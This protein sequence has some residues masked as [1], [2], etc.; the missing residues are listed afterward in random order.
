ML[1]IVFAVILFMI[2]DVYSNDL[3]CFGKSLLENGWMIEDWSVD[4]SNYT[5]PNS[6]LRCFAVVTFKRW[7]KHLLTS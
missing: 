3:L 6:V 1:I 5:M 4:G 2:A 7:T